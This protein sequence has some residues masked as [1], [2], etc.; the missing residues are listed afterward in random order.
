MDTLLLAAIPLGVIAALFI[1]L[2]IWTIL[3]EEFFLS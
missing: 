3:E 1:G 2:F